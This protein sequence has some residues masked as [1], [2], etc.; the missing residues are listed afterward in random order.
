MGVGAGRSSRLSE[1][2]PPTTKGDPITNAQYRPGRE[3]GWRGVPARMRFKGLE[4][5][6]WFQRMLPNG[7][8]LVCGSVGVVVHPLSCEV[9][10]CGFSG[11][12]NAE[13]QRAVLQYMNTSFGDFK[14]E[15]KSLK[16]E[17]RFL[18]CADGTLATVSEAYLSD[19]GECHWAHPLF[20]HYFPRPFG[21]LL[22]SGI[23]RPMFP[24]G[25]R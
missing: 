9:F 17:L 21:L 20:P 15:Y 24:P 19:T 12:S 18:P 22:D 4:A 23:L 14:A 10:R 1:A 25:M 16:D 11:A 5:E 2:L 6:G 7:W 8:V 13:Q 3:E